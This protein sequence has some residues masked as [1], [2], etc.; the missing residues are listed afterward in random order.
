MMCFRDMTFCLSDCVNEKCPR[1]YGED[2]KKAAEEWM[3]NPPIAFTD[4]SE[5]C[6]EYQPEVG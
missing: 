4:F 6:D 5:N 2:D 1:H 3:E